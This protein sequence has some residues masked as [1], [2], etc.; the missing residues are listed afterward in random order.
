M[1]E[2]INELKQSGLKVDLTKNRSVTEERKIMN[3]ILHMISQEPIHVIET[4]KDEKEIVTAII[5]GGYEQEKGWTEKLEKMYSL[6]RFM[7]EDEF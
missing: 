5:L 3:V 6:L 2:I 7:V 1:F 4:Y